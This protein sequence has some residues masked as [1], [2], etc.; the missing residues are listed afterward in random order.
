M[1]NCNIGDIIS[2]IENGRSTNA[3]VVSILQSQATIYMHQS[4]TVKNVSLKDL[5]L[6]IP[7]K[8][9]TFSPGDFVK[10]LSTGTM[11]YIKSIGLNPNSIMEAVLDYK[12]GAIS[13]VPVDNLIVLGPIYLPPSNPCK[14]VN[15]TDKESMHNETINVRVTPKGC[16]CGFIVG[17]SVLHSRW[18]KLYK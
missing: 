10:D 13:V 18:C 2:T 6:L 15:L 12:T 4:G 1:K 3:T 17:E 9:Y 11:A 5:S 16:E 8:Q 7:Y 14:N